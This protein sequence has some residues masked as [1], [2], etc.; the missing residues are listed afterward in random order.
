MTSFDTVLIA[1]R[2]AIACRVERTVRAMGLRSV[3]VYSDADKGSLHVVGADAAIALGGVRPADSYLRTDLILEAARASG[4]GAVHPGYGFLSENADF[5]EAC[6]R[7]G[8]VF[9]GPSAE[10]MRAF[11][12]K[13][14]ARE[15]AT[16]HGVPLTPG[17]A[18]LA[19]AAEALA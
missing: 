14:K 10:Q 16:L 19:D 13:H 7:A 6:E 1:N 17:S 4:A 12:L 18:L 15:L 5:A 8:L 11:G 2:G 3:A 9:I